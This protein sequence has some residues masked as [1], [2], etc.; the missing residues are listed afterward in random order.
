[1]TQLEYIAIYQSW[2]KFRDDKGIRW[3]GR[4][5]D[6]K[7]VKRGEIKERKA[8]PGTEQKLYVVFKIEEWV[9]RDVAIELGGQFIRDCLL[10]SKYMFDRAREIA[11]LRLDTEEQLRDWREKRRQGRV[12]VMLDDTYV[13]RAREVLGV[14]LVE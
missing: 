6:W 11:E 12:K 5:A 3:Y 14:D 4:I 2:T 7:V 8:R 1:L 10:T 13:D 9:K